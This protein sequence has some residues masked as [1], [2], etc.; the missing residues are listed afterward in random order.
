MSKKPNL[1]VVCDYNRKDF[2]DLFRRCKDDFNFF[3]IEYA[4]EQEVKDR[5]FE[6]YGKALFWKQFKGANHLIEATRPDLVVFF[7]IEAY[8]HVALNVACKENG[9]K[10]IHLEHGVRDF[11]RTASISKKAT[12]IGPTNKLKKILDALPL[13]F[14]KYKTRLFYNSTLK[15]VSKPAASFLREYFSVRSRNSIFDTFRLI[16]SPYRIADVYISFS[17]SIFRAH[18]IADHLPNNYPVH[19]IGIPTFDNWHYPESVGNTEKVVLFIDQAFVNQRLL[20]WTL[21]YQQQFIRELSLQCA[22]AGYQLLV[23]LHPRENHVNWKDAES[24]GLLRIIDNQELEQIVGQVP[25]VAGF[26]STMLMPLAAMP[27]TVLF[28]FENHPVKGIFPSKFL[29]ENG[30]AEPIESIEQLGKYFEQVP[31]LKK[32]QA[33]A[34]KDFVEQWLYM[35]DGKA[36]FRL[37]EILLQLSGGKG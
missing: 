25:I 23:K 2:V 28:T 10:T 36:G 20:G 1:L 21:T 22:K 17:P 8:N 29:V 37:R 18:Q 14:T 11:E 7:F 33:I 12:A 24:K 13:F 3:F 4:S 31:A 32:K 26:Y 6:S 9:I 35:L 15:Q 27:Q 5:Y 19:F 30:V 16:K 34:K